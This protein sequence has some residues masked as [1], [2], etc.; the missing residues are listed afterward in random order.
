MVLCN[1]DLPWRE[2]RGTLIYALCRAPEG[3]AFPVIV[4]APTQ[5][6]LE[7]AEGCPISVIYWALAWRVFTWSSAH[8]SASQGGRWR[9]AKFQS[10]ADLNT[11]SGPLIQP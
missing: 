11:E 5:P 2:G 4:R 7:E 6:Q 9:V 10:L 3:Q 8:R 1:S